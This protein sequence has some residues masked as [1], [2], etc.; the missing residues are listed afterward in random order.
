MRKSL[1]KPDDEVA[2]IST[3]GVACKAIVKEVTPGKK[4]ILVEVHHGHSRFEEKGSVRRVER[5]VSGAEILDFW[6]AYEKARQEFLKSRQESSD[7]LA[8]NFVLTD[9]IEK[10]LMEKGISFHRSNFTF[11]LS[12]RELAKL[13]GIPLLQVVK[14]EKS[15]T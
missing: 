6:F 12:Q 4:G 11:E 5:W 9:I 14:W 7:R 2:F 3:P 15:W 10:E 1:L 8:A 13:M